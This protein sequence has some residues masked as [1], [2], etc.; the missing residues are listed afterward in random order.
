MSHNFQFFNVWHFYLGF[1]RNPQ[2]KMILSTCSCGN[3]WRPW[4]MAG[5]NCTK[6]GKTDSNCCHSHWICRCSI[7]MLNKQK[8][9]C[10]NRSMSLVKMRPQWVP[11]NLPSLDP[12]MCQKKWVLLLER[13]ANPFPECFAALFASHRL[14]YK[15][16]FVCWCNDS[17]S[18]LM[19]EHFYFALVS[20]KNLYW[21]RFVSLIFNKNCKEFNQ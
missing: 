11:L 20:P 15:L 2:H 21:R 8:F 16:H 19:N 10:H 7:V 17:M 18:S 3:D 5:K 1:Y 12:Y 14:L 6:C 13:T 4:R 9:C